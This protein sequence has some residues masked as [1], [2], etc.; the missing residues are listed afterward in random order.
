MA[1]VKKNF[2]SGKNGPLMI[3]EI[4]GNH[5]G[6][7]TYAKK[8]LIDAATSGADACCISWILLSMPAG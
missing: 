3:A 1:T 6:D 8:L 5:E 4:G 7:F 2:W